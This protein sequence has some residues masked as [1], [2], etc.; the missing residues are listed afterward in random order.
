MYFRNTRKTKILPNSDKIWA[1]MPLTRSNA[2]LTFIWADQ[3]KYFS[4]IVTTL[5]KVDAPGY[6]IYEKFHIILDDS[7]ILRLK[8][9]LPYHA[10]TSDISSPVLLHPKSYLLR[11]L[12]LDLH[13]SR[14]HAGTKFTIALFRRHFFVPKCAKTVA[15][16]LQKFC[17]K[18][19]C[20]NK[21]PFY[22]PTH[23][24]IPDFRLLPFTS[25]F[26]YVGIDIFGPFQT[27]DSYLP[28]RKNELHTPTTPIRKY[29]GLIFTC[30]ST[31][32]VHIMALKSLDSQELWL[33]IVT[34]FA[35]RTTPVLIMS[36]NALQFKLLAHYIPK[37][38][39]F[40]V[41]TPQISA[42]LSDKNIQWIFTPAKAPWYG[43]VYE[44]IIGLVKEAYYKTLS[45]HPVLTFLS[46][47]T[48]KNIQTM[49]NERPLCPSTDEAEQMVLT[50]AHF[51]RGNLG[52]YKYNPELE[53]EDQTPTGKTLTKLIRQDEHYL[54]YLWKVWRQ[55]YLTH[56][57]DKIPKAL[58]N[59][60]RNI[61]TWPQVGEI[62]HVLDSQ[63][64]PGIYK[65]AK[66]TELVESKD[67]Q[68]R[69]AKIKFAKGFHSE[70]PLIFLAPLE[71]ADLKS[72]KQ[73]K[74]LQQFHCKIVKQS[75][76]T[77]FTPKS[78]NLQFSILKI[79]SILVHYIS[80]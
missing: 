43:G 1:T 44:R 24:Q 32:A 50:P 48:F 72:D 77:C 54:N 8:N 68:I 73:A 65:L 60:Y 40:F 37:F 25:P 13:I 55:L 51:L 20:G 79:Q 4:D 21:K 64:K 36:D 61:P 15:H 47:S 34:F 14:C 10:Y 66:I 74:V 18:C 62:V 39:E 58:P 59:A 41:Q 17:I 76:V 26:S 2:L 56:L 12:V 70:R 42:T 31:R 19:A 16:I 53:A 52:T 22:Q 3:R 6:V 49:L 9:Y 33:Q 78:M 46:K 63:S 30:L 27:F 71:L 28:K 38:W 45:H 80:Y 23:S 35:D 7:G 29:W 75:P 11:L 57:R 69:H 5:S 67:G